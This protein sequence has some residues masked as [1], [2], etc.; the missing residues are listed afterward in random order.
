MLW[1]IHKNLTEKFFNSPV[2][3]GNESINVHRAVFVLIDYLKKL[4][5][6]NIPIRKEEVV[7]IRIQNY[8]IIVRHGLTNN[9]QGPGGNAYSEAEKAR[10]LEIIKLIQSKYISQID[11]LFKEL[12]ITLKKEE[13]ISEEK[14]RLFNEQYELIRKEEGSR[15]A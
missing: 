1:D 4:I 3:V 8:W 13:E 14:L 2:I 9:L 7:L 6:S 11:S 12:G 5:Q 10:A 15:A